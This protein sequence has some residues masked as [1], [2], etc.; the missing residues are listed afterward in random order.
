MEQDTLTQKSSPRN[1]G[2]FKKNIPKLKLGQ[3]LKVTLSLSQKYHG[4]FN[5]CLWPSV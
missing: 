4:I 5:Y 1:L 3:E 2:N